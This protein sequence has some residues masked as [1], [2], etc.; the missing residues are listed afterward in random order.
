MALPRGPLRDTGDPRGP[1]DPQQWTLS[2]FCDLLQG[3]HSGPKHCWLE[4]VVPVLLFP[5]TVGK[6]RTGPTREGVAGVSGRQGPQAFSLRQGS[7]QPSQGRPATADVLQQLRPGLQLPNELIPLA[8][9]SLQAVDSGLGGQ[10]LLL[11]SGNLT[12]RR[13]D[14][15]VTDNPPPCPGTSRGSPSP[16]G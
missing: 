13:Q 15:A 1:V 7:Q 14:R 12:G 8:H 5:S 6:A 11:E 10:Q 16:S 4:V 9:S 3:S 2:P